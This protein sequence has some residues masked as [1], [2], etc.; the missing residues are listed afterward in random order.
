MDAQTV[1]IR[2]KESAE[3]KVDGIIRVVGFM[4]ARFI[5]DLVDALDLTA[6]PRDSKIGP[7]TKAIRD[8]IISDQESTTGQ[9]LPFKSKGILLAASDYERLDRG[10]YRL[11]FVNREIEGILDGGH[12]TLA[13]GAYILEEAEKTAGKRKPTD[14][15]IRIWDVFKDTWISM[16]DDI[17]KYQSALR[18][19][20]R[21][22]ELLGR[23]ISSLEFLVPVEILLP[24]DPDDAI[25]VDN[26]KNSLLEI[27]EARNNNVQLTKGTKGNKQGLFDA[28][29]NYYEE[30]DPKF[31]SEI[32][33]KTNDGGRVDSR[34]LIAFA[35]IP[36]SL[37]KWVSGPDKII[38]M[39][40]PVT[41]YSGKEKCLERYLSLMQD[42]RVSIDSGSDR[43]ELK[44][45]QISSA[46]KIA[47]DLPKLYD[48]LYRLIPEWYVGS[49]GK[50]GAVKSMLDKKNATYRTPFY[51]SEVSKPVPDGFIYPLMYGMKAL[52][53]VSSAT[54]DIVWKTDPI[55]F[56]RS[57]SFH[58]V[59]AQ[60]SENIKGL[61]YDPQKI[62]KTHFSYM[63]A[64][65]SVTVALNSYMNS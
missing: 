36:L 32:S 33:W 37:T 5:I 28:L 11:E 24:A 58:E 46:L 30:K 27:C 44:D 63:A 29:R 40:K 48:E 38:E 22:T 18:D 17:E 52:L 14:K 16:R 1:T 31:A 25:C 57:T 26:F 56:I 9:L 6:N 45:C 61:N 20:N 8:S 59:I 13:I 3:Q 55:K 34:T 10:R 12:N 51:R 39:P 23:G 50:I 2:L 15:S 53:E 19:S 54:G 47:A 41:I 43:K 64:E 42:P 62:G 4:P 7:V 21:K 60:Y 65:N 35:W 49:Y